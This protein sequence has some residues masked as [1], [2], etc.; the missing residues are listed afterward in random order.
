[1]FWAG[2]IHDEIVGPFRVKDT[3][4]ITAKHILLF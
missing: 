4:K 2:I 1:M 3:L